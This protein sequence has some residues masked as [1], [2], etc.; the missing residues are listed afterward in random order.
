M[1]CQLFEELASQIA[2]Q[3]LRDAEL[4]HDA[5][6]HAASCAAC[7]ALLNEAREVAASLAALAAHDKS[8]QSAAHLESS[9]RA[10]FLREHSVV[11]GARPF[12]LSPREGRPARA[13]NTARSNVYVGATFLPR[14]ISTGRW[15]ALSLLAAAITLAAIF[16]PRVF[17]RK[18][19]T[20][21]VTVTPSQ[22]PSNS[23]TTKVAPETPKAAAFAQKRVPALHPAPKK[24]A[25]T[26]DETLT[27]FVMLPYADDP[28]TIRSGSIMRV[29][30]PRSSLGWFGFSVVSSNPKDRVVADFLM[31]Q[32]GTPEAIRLVQ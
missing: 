19:T 16:L 28:S 6:N 12:T 29:S 32:S 2:H 18:P 4:L 27:G 3:E 25:A 5:N 21:Y 8:L 15:A 10:A 13:T 14:D 24:P 1:N 7:N 17:N 23:Q 30:I 31:N 20:D 9:L 11:V 22:A 26:P